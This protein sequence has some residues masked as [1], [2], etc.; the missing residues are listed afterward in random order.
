HP[1]HAAR[2]HW[3]E[4]LTTLLGDDDLR[5]ADRRAGVGIRP[6]SGG[7]GGRDLPGHGGRLSTWRRSG[8][9]RHH[10]GNPGA[11]AEG[12]ATP[13]RPRDKSVRP[14]RTP[15]LGRG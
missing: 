6:R 14:H 9:R 11:V 4:G 12:P 2:P 8:A 15:T 1:T 7:R 13:V 3:S 10:G 5:L